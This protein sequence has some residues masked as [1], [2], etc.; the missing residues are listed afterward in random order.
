MAE[1]ER[2]KSKVKKQ[3]KGKQAP[4]IVRQNELRRAFE[5][6]VKR[7][8]SCDI[9]VAGPDPNDDAGVV[10]H[11]FTHKQE[12]SGVGDA[13]PERCPSANPDKTHTQTE[14]EDE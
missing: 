9:A 8:T 5:R 10:W 2:K 14:E 6:F 13:K 3:P 11:C 7:Q 1:P 4:H 12:W